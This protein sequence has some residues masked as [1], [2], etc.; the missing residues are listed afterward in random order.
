MNLDLRDARPA[1]AQWINGVLALTLVAFAVAEACG[2]AVS[3]GW[4]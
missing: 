1:L 4:E 2:G 3:R